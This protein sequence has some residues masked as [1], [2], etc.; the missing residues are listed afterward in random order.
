MMRP[1]DKVLLLHI[2]KRKHLA[3]ITNCPKGLKRLFLPSPIKHVVTEEEM[4]GEDGNIITGEDVGI[5]IIRHIP[6]VVALVR[7]VEE[8]EIDLHR[9]QIV[10]TVEG[11]WISGLVAG[12][13]WI[14]G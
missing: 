10:G 6:N 5:D 13:D 3:I 8:V 7:A 4:I 9:A 14:Q 12:S 1:A 11:L 2:S